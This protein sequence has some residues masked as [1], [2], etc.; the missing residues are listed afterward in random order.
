MMMMMMMMMKC[1]VPSSESCRIILG[2]FEQRKFGPE[3]GEQEM[4]IT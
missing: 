2:I 4:D 3:K 1:D